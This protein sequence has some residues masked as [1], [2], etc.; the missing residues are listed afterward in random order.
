MKVNAILTPMLWSL[1]KREVDNFIANLFWVTNVI[2]YFRVLSF[3][4][5]NVI[6]T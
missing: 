6:L 1:S 5:V 4:N 3:K 2:I